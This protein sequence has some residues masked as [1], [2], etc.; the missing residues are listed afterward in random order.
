MGNPRPARPSS[1]FAKGSVHLASHMTPWRQLEENKHFARWL[2][3][4]PSTQVGEGANVDS[5]NGQPLMQPRVSSK[6]SPSAVAPNGLDWRS[7]G[8]DRT[9]S[10]T[11]QAEGS[12][13]AKD[14]T[15]T[16][17]SV[18]LKSCF[19]T[20]QPSLV[21]PQ[22]QD[23][24]QRKAQKNQTLQTYVGPK[25]VKISKVAVVGGEIL[26]REDLRFRA[27]MDAT[28]GMR[29]LEFREG[30]GHFVHEELVARHALQI[31]LQVALI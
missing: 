30:E 6:V 16:S 29:T 28:L 22:V 9:A 31:Q 4:L 8:A 19:T 5:S 13:P 20:S 2:V 24:L 1:V 25:T 12:F 7:M 14:D 27:S 3:Q 18:M 15:W 23:F 17:N 10:V 26:D 11:R 21:P